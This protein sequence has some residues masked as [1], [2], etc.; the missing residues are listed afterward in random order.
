MIIVSLSLPYFSGQIAA[1]LIPD[2]AKHKTLSDATQ[3]T[4]GTITYI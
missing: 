4:G 3:M 2:S 1:Q